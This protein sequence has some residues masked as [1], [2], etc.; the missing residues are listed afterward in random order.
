MTSGEKYSFED[1][2]KMTNLTNLTG[3]KQILNSKQCLTRRELAENSKH[4][5]VV[6]IETL[7]NT[8]GDR[9]FKKAFISGT[10]IVEIS[11]FK[12]LQ[13]YIILLSLEFL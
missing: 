3:S 5:G 2:I 6:K 12:N 13:L 8:S 7:Q 10:S 11:S 1:K 9:F 4:V